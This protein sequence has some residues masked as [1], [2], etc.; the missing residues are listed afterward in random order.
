MTR[1]RGSRRNLG[2]REVQCYHCSHWLQIAAQAMTVSCPTCFKHLQVQD[3]IVRNFYSIKVMATCGRVLIEK[4][5]HLIAGRLLAVEGIE[6][7]G[8]CHANAVSGDRVILHPGSV[9]EGDCAAPFVEFRE[10][11][12]VNGGFF[13]IPDRTY[14]VRDEATRIRSTT[15]LEPV[16]PMPSGARAAHYA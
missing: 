14:G 3:V 13:R 10:G 5:G 1:K 7:V 12:V 9:W 15:G 6:V 8:I 4:R 2:P 11:A 16:D